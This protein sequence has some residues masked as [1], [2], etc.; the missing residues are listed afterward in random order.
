MPSWR[1]D[2]HETGEQHKPRKRPIVPVD[3]EAMSA[4]DTMWTPERSLIEAALRHAVND[5]LGNINRS[6]ELGVSN[7]KTNRRDRVRSRQDAKI[8]SIQAEALEFV[9]SETFEEWCRACEIDTLRV[10]KHIE[11]ELRRSEEQ[12]DLQ[13]RSEDEVQ[14]RGADDGPGEASEVEAVEVPRLQGAPSDGG[15]VPGGSGGGPAEVPE[16]GPPDAPV[17]HLATTEAQDGGV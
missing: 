15:D 9:G 17:S 6:S 7:G 5:A 4:G 14:R 1:F 10:R 3:Y 11:R 2:D 12:N 13:L 8:A 16:E